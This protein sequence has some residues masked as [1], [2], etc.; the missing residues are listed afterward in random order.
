[1]DPAHARLLR[2]LPQVDELLRHPTLLP[3]VTPLPR[4]LATAQVRRTLAEIRERLSRAPAADLPPELDLES[5]RQELLQ[6]LAGA[7][8]TS[9]R[10]VLNATGVVIHT[11]LG[12]SLLA[13]PGH[14]ADR[15]GRRRLL[16]PGVHLASGRAGLPDGPGRRSF[17][18]AH[19]GRGR[20]GGQQQRRRGDLILAGPGR[21]AGRCW[22]RAGQLVEIGGS[23][24]IPDVMAAAAA[25][26]CARWAPPTGPSLADYEPAIGPQTGMLLKVHPSN[27]RDRRV[28]QEVPL[29]DAGRAGPAA[30][31]PAGD[32]MGLG[33]AARWICPEPDAGAYRVSAVL[34]RGRSGD[35]FSG[36]KL[37]GG[38]QA[39]LIVGLARLV[40]RLAPGPPGPGP[41]GR[42]AHPG[43]PGGHPAPLPG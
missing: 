27:F 26:C 42:Q 41:A 33:S 36:D 40:A 31:R 9:L 43:G 15:A 24:R 5:L 13:G 14:G 20:P 18:R 37:L 11:N 21:R 39:G 17:C 1:M 30:P 2:Q 6:K 4:S 19:R 28:H 32:G 22:S 7:G 8:E 23:F 10:R 3:A 16:Q 34:S 38:P 25:R 12:R 29:A 35:C